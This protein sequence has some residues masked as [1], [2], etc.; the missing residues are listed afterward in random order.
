MHKARNIL[1]IILFIE[2]L[3][4][5]IFIGII[6]TKLIDNY[7]KLNEKVIRNEI[8]SKL[9]YEDILQLIESR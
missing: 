3:I 9:Y 8:I 5:L 4:S 7:N 1:I 6:L 2:I